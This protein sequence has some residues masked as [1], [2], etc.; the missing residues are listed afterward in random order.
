MSAGQT[1]PG[2]SNIKSYKF[3]TNLANVVNSCRKHF[4]ASLQQQLSEIAFFLGFFLEHNLI[5]IK[6][7]NLL[8]T[9][10]NCNPDVLSVTFFREIFY[11][12]KI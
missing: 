5:E 8:M 10:I 6:C 11:L 1:H 12:K 2:K 3:L 9:N 7:G 4:W